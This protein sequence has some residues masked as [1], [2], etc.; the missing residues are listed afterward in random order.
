MASPARTLA[1][2]PLKTVNDVRKLFAFECDQNQPDLVLLSLVAGSIENAMTKVSEVNLSQNL[3]SETSENED[4][5]HDM[6]NA[7]LKIEPQ[8]E[9]FQIEALYRKFEAIIRNYCDPGLLEK[10]TEVDPENSDLRKIIKHVADIIWNT[11]SKA[12]YKDRPHL[13]SIHSYLTGNKLDCFGVAFA[14]VA[15]CQ[16]LNIS[17]VHLA[18]SEDHAWVVFGQN[19]T[20]TAEVTWHGKGSEDKRG[21]SVEINK[22]KTSWLYVAGKLDDQ[23]PI[24]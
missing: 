19:G 13:Q 7:N 15:S 5:N 21:Q 4:D 18:L 1:F 23:K 3:T 16:M 14:V 6:T 8:V 22:A 2:F 12:Q 9:Y 24:V 17:E 20:E 10:A 11:L